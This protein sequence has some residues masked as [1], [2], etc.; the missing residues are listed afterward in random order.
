[1]ED[2]PRTR[3]SAL[4]DKKKSIGNYLKLDDYNESKIQLKKKLTDQNIDIEDFLNEN[5]RKNLQNMQNSQNLPKPPKFS[6]SK[7]NMNNMQINF[8]EK[9]VVIKGFDDFGTIQQELNLI[10]IEQ[11]IEELSDENLKKLNVEDVFGVKIDEFNKIEEK[12]EELM[13]IGEN[14]KDEKIKEFLENKKKVN[15]CR[16]IYF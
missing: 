15:F 11:F 3:T 5:K 7:K 10:N 13:K 16:L 6:N 9:A 1:M 8:H 2:L 14:L 12:L 4:Y